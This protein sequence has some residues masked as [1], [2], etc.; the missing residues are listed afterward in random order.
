MRPGMS[1]GRCFTSY[2]PNS[3][4]DAKFQMFNK[5]ESNNQYRSF[6]Q[7]NATQFMNKMTEMC[8]DKANED[9][10]CFVGMNFDDTKK[11]KSLK[12]KN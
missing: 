1:D 7:K 9:C 6:L 4:M 3:E 11:G 10:E 8:E 12:L 5:I 2:I